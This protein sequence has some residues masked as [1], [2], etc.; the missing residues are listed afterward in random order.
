MDRII[1]KWIEEYQFPTSDI[2]VSGMI[3]AMVLNRRLEYGFNGYQVPAMP[4]AARSARVS[5]H[6]IV[7]QFAIMNLSSIASNYE[8]LI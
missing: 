7:P 8:S 2:A 6:I 1:C 4:R 5:S 3:S